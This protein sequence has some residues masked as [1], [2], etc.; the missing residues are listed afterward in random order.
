MLTSTSPLLANNEVMLSNFPTDT[1][2]EW[3]G[4]NLYRSV[5]DNPGDTNY[6]EVAS[7]PLSGPTGDPTTTPATPVGSYLDNA[8]DSSIEA[9]GHIMSWTGPAVTT[10]TDLKDVVAYDASSGTYNY[11]FPTTGNLQFT[12]TKDGSTLTTQSLTVTNGTTL[13]DLASFLQGSLGIQPPR[14]PIE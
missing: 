14:G 3:T 10:T 7:L 9:S 12:G 6:Y 1:T 11:V 5:N 8:T 2:G 4:M 13:K